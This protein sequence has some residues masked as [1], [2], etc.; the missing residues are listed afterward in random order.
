MGPVFLK[1]QHPRLGQPESTHIQ[2]GQHSLH[3]GAPRFGVGEDNTVRRGRCDKL[4]RAQFVCRRFR[5]VE[6]SAYKQVHE[7]AASGH[8]AV[9]EASHLRKF[10]VVLNPDWDAF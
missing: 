6:A 7:A 2:M 8:R 4:A 1:V 10:A 3:P 9:K 5:L